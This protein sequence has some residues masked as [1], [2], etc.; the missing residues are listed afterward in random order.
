MLISLDGNLSLGKLHIEALG[1]PATEKTFENSD[2][3][4]ARIVLVACGIK[5]VS[6]KSTFGVCYVTSD[7]RKTKAQKG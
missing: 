7:P 4:E 1:K 5:I 2:A 3:A 6:V